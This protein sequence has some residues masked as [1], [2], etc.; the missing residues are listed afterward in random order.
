MNIEKQTLKDVC[1]T[2]NH[3][4]IVKPKELSQRILDETYFGG[5][6]SVTLTT[7]S[8]SPQEFSPFL[9]RILQQLEYYNENQLNLA[10]DVQIEAS[11]RWVYEFFKTLPYYNNLGEYKRARIVTSIVNTINHGANF[12]AFISEDDINAILRTIQDTRNRIENSRIYR[13]TINDRKVPNISREDC[14][15]PE[16]STFINQKRVFNILPMLVLPPNGV[17]ISGLLLSTQAWKIKKISGYAL[18]R[19]LLGLFHLNYFDIPHTFCVFAL[20]F[21]TR[22]GLC[23]R[24]R[25]L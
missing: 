10:D 22:N 25:W 21:L 6:I 13:D 2:I 17:N 4:F 15:L 9:Y 23:A 24:S 7:L 1:T 12:T 14:F 20:P 5:P 18:R 16:A 8:E 19:A 11:R 3:F